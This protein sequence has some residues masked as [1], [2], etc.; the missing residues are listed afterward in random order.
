M[1]DPITRFRSEMGTIFEKFIRD[2]LGYFDEVYSEC[3]VTNFGRKYN[4]SITKIDIA[5]RLGNYWFFIQCKFKKLKIYDDDVDLYVRECTA[6]KNKLSNNFSYY[7]I[8]LTRI[9]N[10]EP[11]IGPNALS[12][13]ENA[14]NIYLYVKETELDGFTIPDNMKD[15][16]TLLMK[17]HRHMFNITS[18]T[19]IY[20]TLKE[21]GSN[22][23]LMAY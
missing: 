6:L 2:S 22:D 4:V 8:Y 1:S 23:V 12:T 20:P 18:K 7:L 14:V 21:W 17:L 13:V 15:C 11:K 3:D 10:A 19:N 5:V 9:K 16:Y